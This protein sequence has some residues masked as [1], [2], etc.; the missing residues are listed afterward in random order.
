[1]FRPVT[2][3]SRD[4]IS[5]QANG[6]VNVPSL[7]IE[8]LGPNALSVFISAI[9]TGIIIVLFARFFVRRRER[10][11]IQLLVYF[12]TFVALFQMG[13]TFASWWRISVLDFGNWAAVSDLQWP[14]KIHF[15]L[16]SFIAAPVQL[17][18]IW[19]CWHVNLNRRPYIAFFLVLLVIGSVA[20]EI[21]VMVVMCLVDWNSG[22]THLLGLHA[23]YTCFTDFFVTGIQLGLIPVVLVFLT[24]FRLILITWESAVPPCTCAI[25]TLI[26]C[27]LSAPVISSWGLMLQTVLGKLYL[28]SLF[29]TLEGRAQLAQVT[30]RTHFPTLTGASRNIA[31]WSVRP[32]EPDR[33]DVSKP[34]DLP[35]EFKVIS[36]DPGAEGSSTFDPETTKPESV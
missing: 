15:T 35:L 5:S 23:F 3:D 11:A 33:T 30:D 13:A 1:M 25:A 21:Y 29:V 26:V 34:P 16:S 2:V 32:G 7:G 27:A 17:F 4:A 22:S 12:V 36:S 24:L 9:E 28:I 10:L 14:D 31:A 8:F 6:T 18:L 19:R 20:T